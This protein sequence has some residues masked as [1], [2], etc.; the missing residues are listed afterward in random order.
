MTDRKLLYYLVNKSGLLMAV[1]DFTFAVNV[2]RA[3]VTMYLSHDTFTQYELSGAN[4]PMTTEN[5]EQ[6]I[7]ISV[8][9]ELEDRHAST[10]ESNSSW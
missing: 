6:V 10:R 4:F 3:R 5:V 9:L 2:R 1:V 8:S 7:G